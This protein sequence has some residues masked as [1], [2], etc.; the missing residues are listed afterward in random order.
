MPSCTAHVRFR[1]KSGHH[2]A[3]YLCLLL[4]QSALCTAECS[5]RFIGIPLRRP[6]AA[7]LQRCQRNSFGAPARS[8]TCSQ[9]ARLPQTLSPCSWLVLL[10]VM[11]NEPS[12]FSTSFSSKARR[13]RET[14]PIGVTSQ[15]VGKFKNLDQCKTTASQQG[16]GGATSDLS[17]SRGIY[18]YCAY[19]GAR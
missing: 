13:S 17:L 18:W 12:L 11:A 14:V 2:S 10:P 19:T 3:V 15:V 5:L 9:G 1:G 8:R 16:A 4:T 6:C 7:S